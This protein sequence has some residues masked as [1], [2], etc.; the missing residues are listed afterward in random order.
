MSFTDVRLHGVEL[1]ISRVE[2]V[3]LPDVAGFKTF[4][5]PARA[6]LGTAVRE[7]IGDDV[8]LPLTLQPVVADRAGRAERSSMSPG[9]M[10]PRRAA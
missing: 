4:P 5:E 9:S 8:A 2:G 6:L 10:M 1:E 3:A 7:R